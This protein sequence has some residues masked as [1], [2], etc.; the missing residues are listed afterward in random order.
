LSLGLSL[1]F[2][3][4]YPSVRG[5]AGPIFATIIGGGLVS[6]TIPGFSDA[7]I[8]RLQSFGQGS[9]DG[10]LQERLDQFRSL[11]NLPD[12]SVIG[13]GMA[14]SGDAGIAGA[15][16]VDG[17]LIACWLTMGLAVGAV[18]IAAFV[19]ACGRMMVNAGRS[20]KRDAIA[21]G[22]LGCGFLLHIPFASLANGELGFLFWVF[23]AA[24][25]LPDRQDTPLHSGRSQTGYAHA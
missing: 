3:L 12:S 23:A 17:M 22:A 25:C 19:W 13:S 6:L 8:E 21:L 16:P 11:W 1:L 10:S 15:M 2:C 14:P 7:L 18:C 5:R 24:A 9:N 20:G 4:F